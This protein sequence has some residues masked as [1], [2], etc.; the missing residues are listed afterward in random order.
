MILYYIIILIVIVFI[1]FKIFT[2]YKIK[3]STIIAFTGA[4]GSG[5]TLLSVKLA[6]KLLKQSRKKVI[7]KNR[8]IAFKRKFLKSNEEYLPFP[9]LYS[10][11][12]LKIS[13]N[14]MALE[15]L[16]E[17]LL[18]Q[19]KIVPRS[20]VLI[21]E[22]GAFMNQHQYKH[23]NAELFDEFIRL[24]RHYTLGGH[25]ICNDQAS[26][27]IVKFVRVRIN[28]IYNI[29]SFKTK[30]LGLLYEADIRHMTISEDIKIVESEH[31]EKTASTTY[32]LIPFKKIYD[33][34]CYSDR[35]NFVPL[36]NDY[37]FTSF[38]RLSLMKV[39]DDKKQSPIIVEQ[40]IK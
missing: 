4:P 40:E 31:S 14:E 25:L 3:Y 2:S 13:K 26:D 16:P 24:F 28:Q 7:K 8:V 37:H 17:H 35:Y 19:R 21:D 32:G 6:L 39:P 33:T 38:K 15:L 9:M 10:S 20:I 12:P 23:V 30:F 18:L 29:I 5:K 1:A 11:I 22:I 34:Y 36:K 27:N